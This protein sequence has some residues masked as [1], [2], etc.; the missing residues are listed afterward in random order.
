MSIFYCHEC[1]QT[2]DSDFDLCEEIDGEL[3]CEACAELLEAD[4]EEADDFR[5]A[6]PLEPDFR[7]L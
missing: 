2:R 1:D 4:D 6:N 5:R 7:R 3:V